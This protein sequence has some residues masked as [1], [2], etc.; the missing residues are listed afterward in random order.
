MSG[1][2]DFMVSRIRGIRI[3]WVIR[4]IRGIRVIKLIQITRV[5][6]VSR[7]GHKADCS[8]Q[9]LSFMLAKSG[10]ELSSR[11]GLEQFTNST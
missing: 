5:I 4:A 1:S 6:R 7:A 2:S 9:H 8:V 11:P 10:L 3:A